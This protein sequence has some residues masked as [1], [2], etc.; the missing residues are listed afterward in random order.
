MANFYRIGAAGLDWNNVGSWSASSGGASNGSGQP[1]SSDAVIFDAS[2]P[3]TVTITATANCSTFTA[4]KASLVITLNGGNL[5]CAGTLTATLAVN[6]TKTASE[7]VTTRGLSLPQS[8]TGTAKLILVS[9]TWSASGGFF[10][11]TALDLQPTVGNITVSGTVS[12]SGGTITHIP[13]AF[14]VVTTGSTLSV[15]G[16]ITLDAPGV[17]WRNLTKTGSTT[18]TITGDTT[19]SGTVTSPTNTGN[20]VINGTGFKL[21]CAGLSVQTNTQVLGTATIRLTGGT[22]Q[23]T[24]TSLSNAG[25]TFNSVIIAGNITLSFTAIAEGV[26][27]SGTL[28]TYE[29]GSIVSGTLLWTSTAGSM[30]TGTLV[31]PSIK[32]RNRTDTTITLLSNL[33]VNTFHANI[34]DTNTINGSSYRLTINTSLNITGTNGVITGNAPIYFSGSAS[35]SAGTDLNI[36][37]NPVYIDGNLTIP[38]TVYYS[39]GTITYLSGTPNIT[40]TPTIV[41]SCGMNTS[42][43]VWNRLAVS[44]GTV[45]PTSVLDVTTLILTGTCT[46]AGSVGWRAD[47]VSCPVTSAITVSLK[48]GVTY[49]I[50]DEFNCY[51]SRIGS[52]VLFTS[53]SAT[54][55]AIMKLPNPSI[56]NVL[57][58]FTRID[59]SLGRSITAFA[60]TITDCINV[61]SYTDYKTV[62]M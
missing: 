29:S 43:M 25:E 15:L 45:T 58:N 60:G 30:D 22:W 23:T 26:Q 53:S 14:S 19:F 44:G 62:N 49:E 21:N 8:I 33:N 27:Y 36:L 7:T 35:W 51:N 61:V 52:I 48:D 32:T 6:F 16:T 50:N 17:T 59:A 47:I 1:T 38:G 4:N 24:G 34:S 5:T 11:M 40:G 31:W 41:N 54:I 57:A 55:K 37:R 39:S 10:G 3:A 2:S 42:G 9:G 13:S 20:L 56:C 18:L 28:I 46:F 12:V